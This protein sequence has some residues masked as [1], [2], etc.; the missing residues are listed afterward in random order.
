M[1][2]LPLE[3]QG[4]VKEDGALAEKVL[5]DN[6]RGLLRSSADDDTDDVGQFATDCE[7]TRSIE[8]LTSVAHLGAAPSLR[9]IS[10][11]YS[12]VLF[13]LALE[14]SIV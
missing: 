7:L 4:I 2:L 5:V 14:F 1:S 8:T 9:R 11:G 3:F 10:Q 12:A 6:R 13:A